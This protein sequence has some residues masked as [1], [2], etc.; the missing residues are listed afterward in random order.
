MG[1]ETGREGICGKERGEEM[2]SRRRELDR[3]G[4]AGGNTV[5]GGQ[6]GGGTGLEE[7]N[8][9][10]VEIPTYVHVQG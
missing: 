1:R 3:G 5:F 7:G 4:R 6:G 2:K 10:Q 8:V 9:C